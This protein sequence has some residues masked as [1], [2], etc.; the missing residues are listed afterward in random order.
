MSPRHL[1]LLSLGLALLFALLFP[2]YLAY[3][4]AG[5][6]A[7]SYLAGYRLFRRPPPGETEEGESVELVSEER[8][9]FQSVL[10][11]MK[12]PVIALDSGGRVELVNRAGLELLDLDSAPF[13]EPAESL[14]GRRPSMAREVLP[15]LLRGESAVLD[16]EVG[17]AALMVH[18]SARPEALLVV[19]HD[20][21]RLRRLETMRR[22]F[23]ANVSHELRT[24]VTVIRAN[25]ETLLDGA[26]EEPERAA[27]FVDALMRNAERLSNLVRDL[28]DLA[29]IE[30]GSN[31]LEPGRVWLCEV[32][33]LACEAV[34]SKA[35]ARGVEVLNEVPP[36]TL[37][38]GDVGALEQIL[39]NLSDNAVKYGREGGR[40]QIGAE[41]GPERV[42]LSVRDDGPGI[43]AEHRD[44]IFERFYRVDAGRSKAMGGTGLG[45]SI[46]RNLVVAMGGEIRLAEVPLGACFEIELPAALQEPPPDEQEGGEAGD[47]QHGA[48]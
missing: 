44:R 16:L 40:V 33:E 17:D 14:F 22:D 12:E 21:T 26:L 19:I 23:V 1:W 34:A 37:V 39:V 30:S 42:R 25:A 13:G 28:L 48:P 18:L 11:G 32:A 38:Q 36:D 15:S 41:R 3:G 29:A 10:D 45:L 31:R 7:L 35:A 6:L 8:R 20:V 47:D 46:V 24:P 43:P 4:L 5:A 27:I 9:R 2:T